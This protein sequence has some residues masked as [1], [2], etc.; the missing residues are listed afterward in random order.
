LSRTQ[1]L[2]KASKAL[3]KA[4]AERSSRQSVL[5]ENSIGK[6]F[7]A[8]SRLPVLRVKQQ[9][10]G[11]RSAALCCRLPSW[12][13][14]SLA[15]SQAKT[16]LHRTLHSCTAVPRHFRS[17]ENKPPSGQTY[18][19]LPTRSTGSTRKR[20]MDMCHTQNFLFWVV[21]EKY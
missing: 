15:T 1:A 11:M 8:E 4:F 2:G 3:G 19:W 13:L 10:P 14:S 16:A 21:H 18:Y 6:G 12:P 20:R 5:G 17:E 7:F 9:A